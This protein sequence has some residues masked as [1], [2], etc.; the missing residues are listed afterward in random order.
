MHINKKLKIINDRKNGECRRHLIIIARVP[1][2]FV[3]HPHK[4][5]ASTAEQRILKPR[6]EQFNALN[7]CRRK[8]ARI[9]RRSPNQPNRRSSLIS[10]RSRGCTLNE[11]LAPRHARFTDSM[12]LCRCCC[13]LRRE[14]RRSPEITLVP[15]TRSTRSSAGAA[16]MRSRNRNA[17]A[18]FR[19]KHAQHSVVPLIKPTLEFYDTLDESEHV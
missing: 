18:R 7:T 11:P 14:L 10:I 13:R 1:M 2:I 15:R 5:V 4:R 16:M 6:E 3:M 8:I 9:P 19:G 17:L 12:T